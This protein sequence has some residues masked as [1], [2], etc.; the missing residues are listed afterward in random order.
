MR[1]TLIVLVVGALLIVGAVVYRTQVSNRDVKEALIRDVAAVASSDIER[2][3]VESLV[4]RFHAEVYAAHA[5]GAGGSQVNAEAYRADML[6]RM[7]GAARDNAQPSLAVK[8]ERLAHDAG[9]HASGDED[10]DEIDRP[11]GCRE[12]GA[13]VLLTPEQFDGVVARTLAKL[14][15][16]DPQAK[17]PVGLP[18]RL[19]CDACGRV[20]LVPAMRCVRCRKPFLPNDKTVASTCPACANTYWKCNDPACGNTF[21]ITMY[22]Q[23]KT[24][25]HVGGAVCPKCGKRDATHMLLCTKCNGYYPFDGHNEPERCP[26]CG[27]P[28]TVLEPP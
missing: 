3:Y 15:E 10:Q 17:P 16:Q 20:A 11:F 5:V 2:R 21:V 22:E 12:C 24:D 19:I 25:R 6:K 23:L 28:A 14:R 27:A 13:L 26:L 8:L 9:S 18:E 4:E 7:T 1:R